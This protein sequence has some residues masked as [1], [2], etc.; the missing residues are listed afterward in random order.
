MTYSIRSSVQW[1]IPVVLGMCLL[2]LFAYTRPASA[3]TAI[4]TPN[5]IPGSYGLEATKTQPPPKEGA[6]ITTPGNGASFTTS[7]ITVNGI[8]LNDLLVQV[9]N[10]N[11]MVGSVMC[12]GGSFTLQVS[13]FAGTN[14]LTAIVYDD[15]DQA[16]PTSTVTTVTY[17]DSRLTAFGAS[18]TLTSSYGRRSAAAGSQLSWPLQLSGGAGPYAF[19]IDWGDGAGPE[20]KSQALS[21]V[22]TITHAYKK[23]GIYQVNIKVTDVNGVSAFLQVIAVSSGKVDGAA[24]NGDKSLSESTGAAKVLWIP[25]VVSLVLLAPAFWLG[26]QSQLVSL[27]NKM[28]R[29]RDADKSA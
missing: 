5:P 10:N 2:A 28:L 9:Y 8:C 20:L 11:V 26:R 14:E 29:E 17:N 1:T 13:L 21:G 19:S 16:G 7:P 25:T 18:I 27:R 3:I 6:T 15:L 22:V 23:A 4:P 12:K 24:A